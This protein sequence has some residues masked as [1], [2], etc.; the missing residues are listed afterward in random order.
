M[1]DIIGIEIDSRIALN[2][3]LCA[4][5]RSI[6]QSKALES[7]A[8]KGLIFVNLYGVYEYAVRS[9][10]QAVLA[11]IRSDRLCPRDLHSNLLALVLNPKFSSVS[12]AGRSKIWKHRFDLIREFESSTPLQMLD[13][14]LFPNDGSHY[15]VGQLQ[16]IWAVFG[17]DVPL[18]S[19]LRLFGRI[20]ELVENRNAI[21]HG[22]RTPEEVGGRYS[23]SEI[24]KRVDD[25]EKIAKHIVR[26]M[27][28]HY[29]SGGVR[30]K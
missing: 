12:A 14:T 26:E 23:Q 19:E 24:E 17:I 25:I 5:V 3:Q 27:E 18:L 1:F 6:E 28:I 8:C 20:D 15:R 29:H 11:A 16:T 9:G 4:M 21:A 22:R 10:V 2:K 30:R 7:A 13:D